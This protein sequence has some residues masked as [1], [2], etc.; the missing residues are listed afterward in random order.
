MSD[1]QVTGPVSGG[2]HGRPFG[3]STRDLSAEGY[4]EEEYFFSGQAPV[5]KPVGELNP[6]TWPGCK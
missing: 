1:I 3:A 6:S 2:Q 4:V 5:Y